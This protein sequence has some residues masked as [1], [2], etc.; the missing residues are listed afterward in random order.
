MSEKKQS[1]EVTLPSGSVATLL[2]YTGRTVMQAQRIY[3]NGKLADDGLIMPIIMQ[4]TVL[5]DGEGRT[6]DEFLDLPGT[7]YMTLLAELGN[8]QP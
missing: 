2:P 3:A 7:D 8:S 1:R 5:I 6:Y 4:L